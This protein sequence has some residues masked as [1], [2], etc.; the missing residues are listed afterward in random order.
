MTELDH[1]P[2]HEIG[3]VDPDV[4]LPEVRRFCNGRGYLRDELV[5]TVGGAARADLAVY[6]DLMPFQR[7]AADEIAIGRNRGENDL[8]KV[9]RSAGCLAVDARDLGGDLGPLGAVQAAFD[10]NDAV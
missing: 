5:L 3:D 4:P 1:L 10:G 6:E 2:R 8:G 7:T 9:G